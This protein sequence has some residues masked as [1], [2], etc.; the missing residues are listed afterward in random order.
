MR[1]NNSNLKVIQ[2]MEECY[3]NTMDFYEWKLNMKL[4]MNYL[5]KDNSAQLLKRWL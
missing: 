2:T 1:E 4:L 5:Q 3:Y